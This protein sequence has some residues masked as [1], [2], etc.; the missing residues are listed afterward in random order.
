MNGSTMMM[1]TLTTTVDRLQNR[2]HASDASD[3]FA[4][5]CDPLLRD[6][7]ESRKKQTVDTSVQ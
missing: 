1:V 3:S 2:A 4:C 7:A 5:G 6:D